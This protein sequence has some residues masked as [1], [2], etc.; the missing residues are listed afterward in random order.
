MKDFLKSHRFAP[1][2]VSAHDRA[3]NA[4]K[5]AQLQ[6]SSDAEREAKIQLN[7]LKADIAY[8]RSPTYYMDKLPTPLA[9][10]KTDADGRFTMKLPQGKYAIAASATREVLSSTESYY[11]L[12]WVDATGPE[13][14]LMLS[15]D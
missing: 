1:G 3:V 8:Y 12:V 14:S 10:S 11:W 5:S 7:K 2:G 15:N 4:A 6:K 9:S 13:R